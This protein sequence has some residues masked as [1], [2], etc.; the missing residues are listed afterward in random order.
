MMLSI[1]GRIFK[2]MIFGEEAPPII[3]LNVVYGTC[4][5]IVDS[6]AILTSIYYFNKNVREFA[7]DLLTTHIWNRIKLVLFTRNNQQDNIEMQG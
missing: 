2:K 1:G 5:G 3:E 4:L 7:M 6:T